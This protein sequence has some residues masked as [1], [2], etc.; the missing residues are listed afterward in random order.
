MTPGAGMEPVKEPAAK[1]EPIGHAADD[2]DEDDKPIPG[3]E[4]QEA[5]PKM[6]SKLAGPV[7][8]SKTPLEAVE[9]EGSDEFSS[10][11]ASALSCCLLKDCLLHWIFTPA[12][13]Q[14]RLPTAKRSPTRPPR[15]RRLLPRQRASTLRHKFPRQPTVWRVLRPSPQR[16]VTKSQT[17]TRALMLPLRLTRLPRPSRSPLLCPCR[18]SRPTRRVTLLSLRT[19]T[20]TR[21]RRELPP[22]TTRPKP[23]LPPLPLLRLPPS[24]LKRHLLAPQRPITSPRMRLPRVPRR[25]AS[26]YEARVPERARLSWR[27]A[28]RPR[29]LRLLWLVLQCAQRLSASAR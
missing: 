2:K 13:M 17:Q 29:L 22:R 7:G 19:M 26:L 3:S 8:P 14:M 24:L 27:Q 9:S 16:R 10:F 28:S 23:R 6:E 11:S 12:L 21:P 5:T 1:V 25:A 4:P 20:S 15:P 18:P